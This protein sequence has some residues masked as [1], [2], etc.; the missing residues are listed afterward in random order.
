MNRM[1]EKK[2]KIE[3]GS[4]IVGCIGFI[5]LGYLIGNNG[6]T[7]MAI[8][9]ECISLFVFLANGYSADLTGRMLRSRRRKNQ[10]L[11]AAQLHKTILIMQ[12][13]SAVLWMAVYFLLTDVLASSVIRLPFLANAMK[14]LTPLILLKAWQCVILGYFQG[15][16]S[17]MPTV[18]CSVFRQLL[19]L[20]FSLLFTKRLTDYGSKV[21]VLLNNTD[22]A[23]MY[24]ALGLCLAMILSELLI[25]LFLLIVY[26][27]S[28]RNREKQKVDD[29]FQKTNSLIERI[30]VLL[31]AFVPESG[32]Q[33]LKK[34][35]FAAAIFVFL[36]KTDDLSA[37]AHSYGVFYASLVCVGS[38]LILILC[39]RMLRILSQLTAAVRRKDNRS[40]RETIYA[41]LHYCWA[42][43]LFMAVCMAVLASS[44]S[45]IVNMDFAESLQQYYAYG[46]GMLLIIVLNIFLW[47]VLWIL[48]ARKMAYTL[49]ILFNTVFLVSDLLLTGRSVNGIISLCQ[50]VLIAGGVQLIAGFFFTVRKYVLQPDIIHGIILPVIGAVGMGLVMLFVQRGLSP[51]VSSL[52][53]LLL[54]VAIGWIVYMAILLLTGS[55]REN[56]VAY[57][58]GNLGQRFFRIFLR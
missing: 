29:G 42:A 24:G 15:I 48:G 47:R 58:Y 21:S 39:I 31:F 34:L 28:D 49:L 40:V 18:V 11:D 52:V 44:I 41:G 12:V 13:I 54:C 19:F 37:A 2:Q 33:I 35:P 4:Y 57:V 16:G 7:Y 46:A 23:G 25:S 14:I 55:I 43:G 32:K 1:E 17:N 27:G 9:M 38:V 30:R 6:I 36:R 26:I 50:A 20:L 56:K 5:L 53:C 10:Y 8:I 3:Y 22:F 45:K 51:H